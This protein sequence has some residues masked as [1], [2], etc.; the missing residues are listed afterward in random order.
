MLHRD[1]LQIFCGWVWPIPALRISGAGPFPMVEAHEKIQLQQ[2]CKF[3]ISRNNPV[4]QRRQ[5]MSTLNEHVNPGDSHQD[6]KTASASA[7]ILLP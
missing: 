5:S 4:I 6:G 3:W 7:T 2:A 1:W